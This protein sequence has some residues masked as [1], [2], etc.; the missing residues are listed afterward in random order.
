MFLSALRSL[1]EGS[2]KD[3]KILFQ[4][5]LFSPPLQFGSSK[6]KKEKDF[7]TPYFTYL[8]VGVGRKAGWV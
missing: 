5:K 7:P 1:R 4:F 2:E 8:K 3:A 6:E